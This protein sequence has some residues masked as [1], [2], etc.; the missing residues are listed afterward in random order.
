MTAF[1]GTT[2]TYDNSGNPLSYNNG[3]AYT[4]TWDGRELASVVTGGVTTSYTYGADGLRTQK[5]YGSTTY[6]YYYVDGRLVRMTWANSY[7]DF[8]YDESGS[9]Y[10]FVYDGDQYYFVKNVQGDVVQIYSIWGTKA[11]EYSYDAWGNCT[12]VY[13]H[14][15]YGDLAEINPIRYRGYVYDF[16]TGFYYLQSRYYDPQ[17]KRFINA[18]DASLLGANGDFASFNLYS[19]CG[20]NPVSRFDD[21]GDVWNILAGAAIGAVVGVVSQMV[22]NTITGKPLQ[23]GLVKAAVTGAIGG[24]LTAA[25]PGASTLINIGVSVADSIYTDISAGENAATVVV[26]AALSAGFAAISS[27]GTVFSDKNLAKNTAKAVKSIL[28]GNHPNVKKVASQF[29]KKTGKAIFNEVC[30]GVRE[31]VSIGLARDSV[32]WYTGLYTDAIGTYKDIAEWSAN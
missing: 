25:F 1:N 9:V 4:F 19:Y 15:S 28:P 12:V 2:I 26:N 13:E 6:N 10:S 32:K 21:G 20:N 7:I 29:L 31:G 16:E 8:L 17:V 22:T 18:D 24:G 23:N 27:G 5:Q 14:S 11:V 3:S 30:S